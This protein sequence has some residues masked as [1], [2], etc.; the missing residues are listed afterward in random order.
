MHDVSDSIDVREHLRIC[1]GRLVPCRMLH[2]FTPDFHK[3][4]NE[5]TNIYRECFAISTY[6]ASFFFFVCS[7]CRYIQKYK[8]Y[9]LHIWYAI[10][11]ISYD[12][13]HHWYR[14]NENPPSWVPTNVFMG[15]IVSV[16]FSCIKY[17]S[18]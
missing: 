1:G 11:S 6:E 3:A 16:D 4:T 14:C 2:V 7:Y 9:P 15:T 5:C 18:I 13:H 17:N 10:I 8:M 12:H